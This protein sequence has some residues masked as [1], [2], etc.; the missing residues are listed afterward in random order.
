V[1]DSTLDDMVRQ[2]TKGKLITT[3]L[4]QAFFDLEM[5][6][7]SLHEGHYDQLFK[8]SKRYMDLRLYDDATMDMTNRILP[9]VEK[10]LIEGNEFYEAFIDAYTKKYL[11]QIAECEWSGM[12][13]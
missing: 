9:V 11:N 6:D 2:S 4:G 12:V 13:N 5:L 7:S 3:K 1:Y 8:L 10:K